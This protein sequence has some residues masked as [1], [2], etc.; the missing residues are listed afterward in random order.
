MASKKR[1]GED[2]VQ[3]VSSEGPAAPAPALPTAPAQ[4]ILTFDRYFA[5]TGKPAHHKAGMAKYMQ[6]KG[7]PARKTKADWDAFFAQY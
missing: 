4:P 1:E 6:G 5:A 2:M 7:G 3:S